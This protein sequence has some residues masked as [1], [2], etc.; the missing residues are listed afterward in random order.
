MTEEATIKANTGDAGSLVAVAQGHRSVGHP[1]QRSGAG[2]TQQDHL[3]ADSRGSSQPVTPGHPSVSARGKAHRTC[4]LHALIQVL[5][6]D[7][8]LV[9]LRTAQAVLRLEKRHSGKIEAQ[10]LIQAFI[11]R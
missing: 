6:A 2:S 9:N 8:I 7:Q 10:G 11:W 5:F 3:P 1:I 4:Q